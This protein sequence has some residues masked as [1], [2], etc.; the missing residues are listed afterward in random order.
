MTSLA[1][2]ENTPARPDY[3]TADGAWTA[4][5]GGVWW[6]ADGWIE[7]GLGRLQVEQSGTSVR[8]AWDPVIGATQYQVL[9]NGVQVTTA[10]DTQ[11]TIAGLTT[12]Q[13]YVFSVMGTVAGA[14]RVVCAPGSVTMSAP[15][16]TVTNMTRIRPFP[17]VGFN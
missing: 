15:T 9:Q 2:S 5:G 6:T 11:A 7:T 16:Y 8:L 13:T 10:T 4:D 17:S 3:W 14:S 1:R 12:G